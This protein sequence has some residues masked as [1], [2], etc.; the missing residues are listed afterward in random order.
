MNFSSQDSSRIVTNSNSN[1]SQRMSK[2]TE[3]PYSPVQIIQ[4]QLNLEDS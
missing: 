3:D 1:Q 4:K 2:L